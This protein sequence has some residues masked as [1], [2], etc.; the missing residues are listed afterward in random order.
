MSYLDDAA[1]ELDKIRKAN[2]E[3][4]GRIGGLRRDGQDPAADALDAVTAEMSFRLAEAY[5]AL[6]APG[7][8][9]PPPRSHADADA[10]A[11]AERAAG[12]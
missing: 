10:F 12:R 11:A 5:A 6:A 9:V 1:A 2:D 3:M 8:D 7:R 4:R